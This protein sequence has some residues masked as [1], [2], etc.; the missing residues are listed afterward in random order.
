M[1]KRLHKNFG[2][3]VACRFVDVKSADL[4]QFPAIQQSLSGPQRPALPLVVIDGAV[5]YHGLFSPTFIQRD[6]ERLLGERGKGGS[7]GPKRLAAGPPSQPSLRERKSGWAALEHF[8]RGAWRGAETTPLRQPGAG[9]QLPST[10]VSG[11]PKEGGAR[12]APRKMA[13]APL[14]PPSR[15]TSPRPQAPWASTSVFRR[16]P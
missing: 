1:A 9:P 12:S 2:D 7:N 3:A 11:Q 16:R 5:R 10:K 6:V 15:N 4:A 14:L 8:A 13:S